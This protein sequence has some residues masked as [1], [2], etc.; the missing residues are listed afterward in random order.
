MLRLGTLDAASE[1]QGATALAPVLFSRAL[2]DVVPERLGSGCAGFAIEQLCAAVLDDMPR[3][4]H[5][6]VDRLIDCGVSVNAIFDTYIPRASAR[7]GEMWVEDAIPFTAVAVGMSRLTEVFR[8]LSRTSLKERLAATARPLGGQALFAL[9]P[10][11]THALGVVMAADCFRRNG[12]SVRVELKADS[13]ELERIV[14]AEPFDAIG[15]SAGSRRA[16]PDLRGIIAGLREAAHP[17]TRF[18]LGGPLARLDERVAE[19]VGADI[20]VSTAQ[21]AV[22]ELDNGVWETRRSVRRQARR[23]FPA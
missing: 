18:L 13:G 14:R 3:A 1:D 2:G 22:G 12:W 9:G 8:R 4:A 15:L 11:E 21:Q 23:S 10:G 6:C 16:I 7:M 5:T 19:Q 17:A 20:A